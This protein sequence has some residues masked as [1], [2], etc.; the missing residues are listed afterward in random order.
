MKAKYI[1]VSTTGQNPDRQ[2]KSEVKEYLDKC[3]FAMLENY[4][5]SKCDIHRIPRRTMLMIKLYKEQPKDILTFNAQNVLNDLKELPPGLL[6]KPI[7]PDNAM[8]RTVLVQTPPSAHQHRLMPLMQ[9]LQHPT[10]SQPSLRPW[11]RQEGCERVTL[12]KNNSI[13]NRTGFGRG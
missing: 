9:H 13:L 11:L 2:K 12:N 5:T 3:E 4:T 1:R 6:N 7:T 10:R 8:R